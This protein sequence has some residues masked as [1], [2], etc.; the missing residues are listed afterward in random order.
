MTIIKY[1]RDLIKTCPYLEEYENG[2]GVD[3]LNENATSYM[4]ESVPVDPI[5]KQFTDGGT[6]RQFAFNFASRNGYGSD[7][8][9]NLDNIGFFEHFS[10]WVEEL[11]ESMLLPEI[12]EYRIPISLKV[13]SQGYLYNNEL[14]EAQYIIQCKFIFKQEKK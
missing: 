14:D 5:M 3:Y 13:V 4:I 1:V 6:V 11:T 12:D 7:V 8:I 2:I 9:E 10:D